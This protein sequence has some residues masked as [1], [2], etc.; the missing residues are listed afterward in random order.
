MDIL[1]SMAL[2][3]DGGSQIAK[4]RQTLIPL[5]VAAGLNGGAAIPN[6]ILALRFVANLF[7]W[8]STTVNQVVIANK[9][10]VRSIVCVAFIHIHIHIQ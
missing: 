2:H 7:R 8:E 3:P 1:R 6:Q 5:V 4:Y 9:E 10:G